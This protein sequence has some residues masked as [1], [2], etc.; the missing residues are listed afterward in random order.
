MTVRRLSSRQRPEVRGYLS[1][2][3]RGAV[4]YDR[5]A[6]Y[7]RSSVFE[8]P[9]EAF[10]AVEGPVRI[11]CNSGLDPADVATAQAQRTEWCAGRPERMADAQ[12]PR[13]ERLAQLLRSGKVTV[14]VLP[15]EAFGLI[16]GKAGV[17]R[18]DGRPALAFLGSVNE[19]G[20]AWGRN[21]ELLWEDDDPE[22]VA[23]VQREF[24]GLWNHAHARDLS[25]AIVEDVERILRRAVVP[26]ERWDPVGQ[27][28]APFI[29]APVARQGHGVAPYQ[30]AF[31]ATVAAEI[32]TYGQARWHRQL[33]DSR[34]ERG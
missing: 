14:K 22:A 19:T 12:R 30:Q 17:L 23:W 1:D 25:L 6:G 33:I 21:Y 26:V 5:I 29:E 20:S 34:A 13:Y 27:Q 8:V 9:G 15:D 28:Q 18:Y 3:L 11:V 24:D 16:H 2:R 32:A 7:F 31:V 4:S 10:D